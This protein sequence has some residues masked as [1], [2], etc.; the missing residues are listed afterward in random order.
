MPA[1]ASRLIGR[2]QAAIKAAE[3]SPAILPDIALATINDVQAEAATLAGQEY[4]V[5]FDLDQFQQN[6]AQPGRLDVPRPG[7]GTIGILDIDRMGTVKDFEE[8]K[9]ERLFHQGTGDRAGVWENIVYPDAEWRAQV[10]LERQAV[11]GDKTP[12]WMFLED[13][14]SGN[15]AFPST[16]AHHFIEHGTRSTTILQRMRAAASRIF[17]GI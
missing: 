5:G 3:A 17:A 1:D 11:W 4:Q 2:L 6:I 15:G 9:G 7:V 10:A 16:P 13:G 8:I 14:F 12:Q